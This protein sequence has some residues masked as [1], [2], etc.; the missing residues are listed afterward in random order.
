VQRDE[1]FPSRSGALDRDEAGHLMTQTHQVIALAD[2]RHRPAQAA[3]PSQSA[4]D[5]VEDDL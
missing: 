3:H 4:G 5:G 1:A 2:E